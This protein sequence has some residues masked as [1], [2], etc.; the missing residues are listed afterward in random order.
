MAQRDG[1][2]PLMMLVIW[3]LLGL[4]SPL[5]WLSFPYWCTA[6]FWPKQNWTQ[7]GGSLLV[8]ICV[9]LAV[10]SLLDVVRIALRRPALA[11]KGF[12]TRRPMLVGGWG[13]YGLLNGFIVLNSI[14]EWV[15][16][17][18][19]AVFFLVWAGSCLGV[20]EAWF[21]LHSRSVGVR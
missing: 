21:I 16:V 4:W 19:S 11:P 13:G 15:R 8:S 14:E 20:L 1:Q 7:L 6:F 2:F 10:L 3:R 12:L 17:P 5:G 18:G 9:L